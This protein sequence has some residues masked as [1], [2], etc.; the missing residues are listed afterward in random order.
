MAALLKD[1]NTGVRAQAAKSLGSL[2][3]DAKAALPALKEAQKN[4]KE[5]AVRKAA[6]DAV[7]LITRK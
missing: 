1:E 4:D 5:E 2:G 7:E 3:P 6:E